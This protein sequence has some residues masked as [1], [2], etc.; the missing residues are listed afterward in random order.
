MELIGTPEKLRHEK[1]YAKKHCLECKLAQTGSQ[2]DCYC[3]RTR[4][5]LTPVTSCSP[6][7]ISKDKFVQNQCKITCNP[8]KN[9]LKYLW[10]INYYCYGSKLQLD[11]LKDAYL[12]SNF[13]NFF[14][15][16]KNQ[17]KSCKKFER[18]NKGKLVELYNFN[19]STFM[20]Y[21]KYV[22]EKTRN[23]IY[24]KEVVQY[25]KYKNLILMELRKCEYLCLYMEG[26][27]ATDKKI[28]LNQ[29]GAQPGQPNVTS[30]TAPS[31][32]P[33]TKKAF[34]R[35]ELIRISKGE[36]LMSKAYKICHVQG[37]NTSSWKLCKAM[38]EQVLLIDK[39]KYGGLA[40][41][42][43]LKTWDI[44]IEE[45]ELK[46]AIYQLTTE[47]NIR[48]QLWTRKEVEDRKFYLRDWAQNILKNPRIKTRGLNTA[49][50]QLKRALENN[51]GYAEFFSEPGCQKP[52]TELNFLNS[53]SKS[54]KIKVLIKDILNKLDNKFSNDK[55]V[56]HITQKRK[57]SVPG[58]LNR[59][60]LAKLRK[61]L[62]KSDSWD[63]D[64]GALQ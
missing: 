52:K 36:D 2:E 35:E 55:W 48:L 3:V 59:N 39:S 30:E 51:I 27:K 15:V 32:S 62:K 61:K 56:N 26:K 8:S 20:K 17:V 63:I 21:K 46:K 58:F 43:T 53:Y 5:Y 49:A 29:E 7:S 50:K 47:H 25:L 40:F 14:S 16:F 11:E 13:K 12:S 60:E 37:T 44:F 41:N 38:I 24:K 54:F 57:S 34:S 42:S 6:N 10:D 33:K 4:V 45:A 19:H 31:H 9:P 28:A 64:P 23:F 18:E 22:L 1:N